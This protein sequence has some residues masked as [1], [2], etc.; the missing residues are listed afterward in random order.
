MRLI[1]AL[2][3]TAAAIGVADAALAAMSIDFGSQYIKLAIVKTG[4]PMEIVL[5]KESRRKTPNTLGIKNGERF[6]ADAA[7][8]LALK[9]PK[10]TYPYLLELIGKKDADPAIARY[11]LQFPFNEFTTNNR[12]VALFKNGE[13]EYDIETLLAMILWSAKKTTEAYAEQSVKD[14]VITVPAFFNQA[15]RR[16]IALAADIAGLN[17]LQILNS[18]SAAALN[19]G[20]FRRKEISE[21]STTMLIYDMGAVKTDATIVEYQLVEDKDKMKNPVVRTL[22]YGYDR[23]LGGLEMTL[24]LQKHLEQTFRKEKKTPTDIATNP[25]SM[26]KLHKEAER[27]KQILSA[28]S[29]TFAQIENVHEDTDFRTEVNREQFEALIED[30]DDRIRKPITDALVMADMDLSKIDQIV[31]MG[32]GTRIPRVK[33]VLSS[34]V[35]G[36]EL[37][38]FLNTDEAIAMGAV[39]QSAKLSKSFKVLTFDIQE[40]VL[41]PVKIDFESQDEQ[42]NK[43]AASKVLFGHKTFYP[44]NKK[45]VTLNS[46]SDDFTIALNYADL[47]FDEIQ[48]TE[49]GSRNLSSISVEGVKVKMEEAM[50]GE[51]SVFKG[52]KV[53][54]RID[55]SGIVSLDKVEL[56][57]E[58]PPP[59]KTAEEIAEEEA[60]LAEEEAKKKEEEEKKKNDQEKKEDDQEKKEG[61][62]D[63]KEDTKDD[64]KEEKK[65]EKK[66]EEKKE[67][68]KEEPKPKKIRVKMT[69]KSEHTDLTLP[70]EEEIVAAK[71]IL[72]EFE[73]I[74]AA[75]QAREEAQN[76]LEATLYD[77]NDKLETKEGVI[78]FMTQEEQEKL[79]AQVS[80]LRTWMEDEAGMD[81]TTEEFT[82]KKKSVDDITEAGRKRMDEYRAFP[83]AKA[84]LDALFNSTEMFLTLAANMTKKDETDEEGI[85][86]DTEITTLRTK[87]EEIQQWFEEKVTAQVNA[88]K[89]DDPSVTQDEIQEKG[90]QLQRE[91][92]YL[93]N[94]MASY[95]P[96]IKKEEKKEEST[97]EKE[98]SENETTT[99]EAE[100]KEEAE[101]AEPPHSDL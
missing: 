88:A 2:L 39:Y 11:K 77:L 91:V 57:V 71:K 58:Q 83:Q 72:A 24:R 35:G 62:D 90:V 21:Q 13:S 64:M 37:G 20:V 76:G 47:H 40:P 75:K 59:P 95:K 33:A 45:I 98:K 42:G 54:V 6:F 73:S 28:N 18:G 30:L 92:K 8:Q 52:F 1:A 22:G 74:E 96:K 19:Y 25:R 41:F 70:N 29:H 26:A 53:H 99:E 4:V 67:K 43:K 17:L 46:Y 84:D 15:E 100:K 81:T 49:F 65:E 69:V 94:K 101:T 36:R 23:S 34:A 61:D 93:Y 3:L 60:A 68:K 85:F 10:S 48:A 80:L 5:N 86:N 16:A 14:V 38:N 97:A 56:N 12:G 51:G 79:Q 63:K 50:S 31:L 27:V 87:Y 32:A 9:Q 66:V 44:A 82:D 78:E 7:A 55:D 89:S